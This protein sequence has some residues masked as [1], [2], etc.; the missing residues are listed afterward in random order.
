MRK[1]EYNL[2]LRKD[3]CD[4]AI[5]T[6]RFMGGDIPIRSIAIS[7]MFIECIEHYSDPHELFFC[8]S[9]H[10]LFRKN[11]SLTEEDT[12]WNFRAITNTGNKKLIKSFED[13]IDQYVEEINEGTR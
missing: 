13:W 10:K 11:F 8:I 1:Y 2:K 12:H 6:L 5:D 4:E 9:W 3:M 7:R